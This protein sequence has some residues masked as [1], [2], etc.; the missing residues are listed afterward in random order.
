LQN[1]AKYIH[2]NYF[3]KDIFHDYF[4]FW[5][6]RQTPFPTGF[7]HLLSTLCAKKA[8][9]EA[10]ERKAQPHFIPA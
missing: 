9:N 7:P 5:M 2:H 6:T 4:P 10:K 3:F 8:L 1:L